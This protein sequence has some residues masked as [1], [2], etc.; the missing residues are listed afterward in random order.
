MK[1]C[2]HLTLYE[3]DNEKLQIT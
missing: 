2:L 1:S 3:Q